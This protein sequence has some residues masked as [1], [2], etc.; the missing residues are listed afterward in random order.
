M[1]PR[2]P[3]HLFNRSANTS[4]GLSPR[5]IQIAVLRKT[6]KN[7][8]NLV[9][10]PQVQDPHSAVC[11]PL[12]KCLACW[13]FGALTLVKPEKRTMLLSSIPIFVGWSAH[14][15]RWYPL[16]MEPWRNTWAWP[17]CG[18]LSIRHP[19]WVPELATPKL[20]LNETGYENSVP[21]FQFWPTFPFD[22]DQARCLSRLKALMFWEALSSF[23]P[24]LN[25]EHMRVSINRGTPIA[26]WFI[27]KI[28]FKW[29]Q[30]DD[31]GVPP[32]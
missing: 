27:R 25:R 23:V 31:L 17:K 26:G 2:D 28:L 22:F 10:F 21:G 9:C 20:K 4:A 6:G 12:G 14:S 1:G 7:G 16:F 30:M 29:F 24:P 5:P 13:G 19:S 32:F 11:H 3:W 15:T 8:R 18:W